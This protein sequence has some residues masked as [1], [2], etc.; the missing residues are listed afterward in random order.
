MQKKESAE[1]PGHE[2]VQSLN[3]RVAT[4]FKTVLNPLIVANRNQSDYLLFVTHGSWTES[5]A[6]HLRANLARVIHT[7]DYATPLLFY[8]YNS[9]QW[10]VLNLTKMKFVDY[11]IAESKVLEKTIG[12]MI[13]LS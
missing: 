13:K 6:T 3:A 5:L 2:D 1:F 10:D 8:P 4:A 9:K 11:I 7:S 12:Y